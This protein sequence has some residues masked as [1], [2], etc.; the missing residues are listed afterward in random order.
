MLAL[1]LL[2][3]TFIAIKLWH[4]SKDNTSE[5]YMSNSWMEKNKK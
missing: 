4:K 2:T 3:V 5:M 1:G